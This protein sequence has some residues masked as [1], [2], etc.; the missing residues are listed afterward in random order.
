MLKKLI[1]TTIF[2]IFSLTAFSI[3]KDEA[4]SLLKSAETN[5]AFYGTDFRGSY[6][7]I[8]ER[9][10]ESSKTFEAIM[11]RRDSS[12]KWTILLTGP[13]SEKGKGYLQTDSNIW[14]YDPKDN[15][16][17]FSS[18]TDKFR[19]T[20]A[21]NADFGP[22]NYYTNYDIVSFEEVKLGNFDCV[23][24]DL[25]AKNGAKN[26]DYPKLKLWVTKKDGLTR[27]KE[28]YSNSGQKLRTTAIP[29]Y[30]NVSSPSGNYSVP[31][32][33]K[34]QD[35]LKGK[36][37]NGKMKNEVTSISISNVR[38]EKVEDSV[39]TKPYLEMMSAR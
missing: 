20:N 29:S 5:S 10:G 31:V 3:A 21:N 33:M 22:Q 2:S 26:V 24:F 32:T 17:T 9:P 30:Q 18:A 7:I 25:K 35:N 27:K 14:F 11:Y 36:K 38:F 1:T 19:D 28:D 4:T 12:A 23:L 34:I 13:S 8:Q 6:A 16:F 37:I 39:Y 15:R